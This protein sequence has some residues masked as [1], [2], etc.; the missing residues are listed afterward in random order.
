MLEVDIL[1]DS[2][3]NLPWVIDN[4]I[5]ARNNDISVYNIL[6][7]KDPASFFHS[8]WKRG[9]SIEKARNHEF[10]SYYKRFF[11]SN[12]PFISLNYNKLVAE[13][14]KTLRKLCHLIEIPYFEGKENFWEKEHH[15]LFGSRGTRKQVGNPEAAIRKNEEYPMEY[16]N[17]IPRIES[18]NKK[19][20]VFQDIM[21]KLKSNELHKSAI[22]LS[23]NK[24]YKPYWYCL[25]KFKQKIQQRF[26]QKWK[27]KQ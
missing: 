21:R 15:Q 25:S 4:N 16:K 11:E 7:Y 6:I 20:K 14:S 3:K 5:Y 1:V 22:Q 19:N 24:I 8:F 17:I 2:S 9:I 10:I 27:Y 13:P 18:D 26:P 23:D 12:L